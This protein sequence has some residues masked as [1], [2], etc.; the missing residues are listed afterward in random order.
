MGDTIQAQLTATA[1]D[2]TVP[3]IQSYNIANTNIATA[4]DSATQP[5]CI[6]CRFIDIQCKNLGATTIT[7][8]YAN[9]TKASASIKVVGA[10]EFDKSS[11]YCEEGDTIGLTVTGGSIDSLTLSKSGIALIGKRTMNR[12]TGLNYIEVQCVKAGSTTINADGSKATITV[13]Y[14]RNN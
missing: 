12:E 9:G 1:T 6:G 8:T 11:Y 2:G 7:A 4:S 14:N 10:R 3:S 5:K 13:S